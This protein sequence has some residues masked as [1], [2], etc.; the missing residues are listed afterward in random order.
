MPA[1]EPLQ[2]CPVQLQAK[3]ASSDTARAPHSAPPSATSNRQPRAALVGLPAVI[4]LPFGVNPPDCSLS[5]RPF[6]RF[7]GEPKE[8][9]CLA[10]K[11][12]ESEKLPG[13]M[14]TNLETL[15]L[16]T[17]AI[18]IHKPEALEE[19][20]LAAVAE[21]GGSIVDWLLSRI[22]TAKLWRR[23]QHAHGQVVQAAVKLGI[24]PLQAR[25]MAE[26]AQTLVARS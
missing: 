14:A 7:V 24:P 13:E 19:H 23:Y 18:A 15:G 16:E 6:A 8:P 26:I 20:Q 5:G 10:P 11:A 25:L 2:S 1:Q 3:Q 21:L 12:K 22:P 17:Q 4:S 9:Q